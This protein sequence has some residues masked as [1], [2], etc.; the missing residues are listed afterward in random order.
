ML[1][2]I[3]NKMLTKLSR[4][5][6]VRGILYHYREISNL[7]CDHELLD[8]FVNE[9]IKNKTFYVSTLNWQYQYKN[10]DH[11]NLM[12]LSNL[13]L[14]AGIALETDINTLFND[15]LM[16]NYLS[17]VRLKKNKDKDLI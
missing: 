13:L 14:S 8:D 3:R 4:K 16:Q 15:D 9:I 10:K 11:D 2:G 17:A 12:R 6:I 5:Q 7:K 1:F